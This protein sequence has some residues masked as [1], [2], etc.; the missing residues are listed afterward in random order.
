[1]EILVFF[2]AGLGIITFNCLSDSLYFWK[3]SFRSDLKLT[4]IP[5]DDTT[6]NHTSIRDIMVTFLKYSVNKIKSSNNHHYV[7]L[8]M[9]RMNVNQNLQ[10]L[11]FGQIIPE[12]GFASQQNGHAY[13]YKSL[14]TN[15]LREVR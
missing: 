4:I 7:K 8:F 12:R 11:L 5:K 14:K 3:N 9:K 15:D 1:M 13:T 10:F 6:V 2:P